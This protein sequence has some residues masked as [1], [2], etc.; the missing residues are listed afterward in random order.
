[1]WAFG[2]ETSFESINSFHMSSFYVPDKIKPVSQLCKYTLGAPIWITNCV[3]DELMSSTEERIFGEEVP[4]DLVVTGVTIPG[5]LG[6]I[7][8]LRVVLD[9]MKDFGKKTY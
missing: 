3:T 1:M 7:N 5:D 8:K 2:S 9:N 4:I 6:N